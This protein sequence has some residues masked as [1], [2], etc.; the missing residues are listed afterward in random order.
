MLF[1][2]KGAENND[3]PK[4]TTRMLDRDFDRE[5]AVAE[6]KIWGES[7]REKRRQSEENASDGSNR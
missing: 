2:S 4:E 6:A 1:R 5:R 3:S 7:W